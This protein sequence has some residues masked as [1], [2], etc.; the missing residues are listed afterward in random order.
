VRPR[1]SESE[2][3]VKDEKEEKEQRGKKKVKK[4][5]IMFSH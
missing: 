2:L 4:E 5:D 3:T 1:G